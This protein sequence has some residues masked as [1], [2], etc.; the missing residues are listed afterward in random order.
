MT[1]VID[2]QLSIFDMLEPENSEVPAPVVVHSSG[3]RIPDLFPPLTSTDL[4]C[5]WC[6]REYAGGFN[7]FDYNCNHG[8][9]GIDYD[10]T[11]IGMCVSMSLTKGH[12]AN[13]IGNLFRALGGAEPSTCCWTKGDLHGKHIKN[14]TAEQWADH[15]RD[16]AKRANSAWGVR[17]PAFRTW[18]MECL[19]NDGLEQYAYQL[20]F[21]A[22]TGPGQFG[23][24]FCAYCGTR[25]N[26][27]E[28][29]GGPASD[30]YPSYS[31]DICN[32]CS[33]KYRTMRP[34][35]ALWTFKETA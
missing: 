7:S 10:D 29:G 33:D 26:L 13:A 3:P 18:Y 12:T 9:I 23:D 32:P 17:W 35:R 11:G 22:K 31:Y 5:I 25:K 20:P 19:A 27:N 6:G 28:G 21:T 15:V 8:A 30:D 24:K 2:G 16:N 14:A 4:H 1:L 34:P